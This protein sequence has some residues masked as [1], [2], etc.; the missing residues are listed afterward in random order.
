M[1]ETIAEA[2]T[3]TP[4][5]ES[6]FA[7][8][9]KAALENPPQ[10]TAEAPEA[11]Q[12]SQ[13]KP[14]TPPPQA[15]EKPPEATKPPAEDLEMPAEIKSEKGRN[16]W[17]EWKAKFD[18]VAK[19][20]DEFQTKLRETEAGLK[21]DLQRVQ[22]ELD[23]AKKNAIDPKEIEALKAERDEIRLRLK[24]RDVKEDPSWKSEI[25]QPLELALQE[26][27]MNVPKELRTTLKR[28]M[29]E[30][31]SDAR[32]DAIE[33]LIGEL[34]P[35][36]QVNVANALRAADAVNAK[37]AA[38][39][40][41][42]KQL[43]EQYESYQKAERERQ[44]AHKRS[45]FEKSVD[46]ILSRATDPVK[47]LGVFQPIDDKPESKQAALEA[48]RLARQY[49]AAEPNGRNMANLAAWAVQ[50]EKSIPLL[51]AAHAEIQRLNAQLEKLTSKSPTSTS[52]PTGAQSQP[53][54]KVVSFAD[55]V[56]ELMGN[57]G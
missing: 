56:R 12:A 15:T 35:L 36:K 54:A 32:Q 30:P 1:P 19:E 3:P 38:L 23:S 18:A 41:N 11:P 9:F 2:Q 34:S 55:K 7:Q 5:P 57:S 42:Q 16:S 37:Q 6:A 47:G 26:A 25:E 17:K 13:A 51:Q 29:L 44:E 46:E 4:Q 27:Q 21:S 31:P 49:A 10:E 8:A 53:A 45:E 22:S 40:S 52:T 28:L 20:R 33:N 48:A 14:V 39:L 50:G 24:M 43:T